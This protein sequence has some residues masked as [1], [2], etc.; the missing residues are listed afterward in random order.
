MTLQFPRRP[1]RK[2]RAWGPSGGKPAE[3]WERFSPGYEAQAE[4]L[5][6]AIEARGLTARLGGAGSEDGEYLAALRDGELVMLQHLEDPAEA[7][8]LA[9]LDDAALEAMLDERLPGAGRL[10]HS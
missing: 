1:D 7:R 10:R 6:R 8:R 3:I 2:G 9:A 4:R 5:A